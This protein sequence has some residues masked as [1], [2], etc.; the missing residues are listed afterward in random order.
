MKSTAATRPTTVTSVC[1]VY[2]PGVQHAGRTVDDR[3]LTT[4]VA[5]TMLRL[6]GVDARRLHSVE[7]EGTQALPGFDRDRF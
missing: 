6:L 5:P 4:Q 7:I 3:V 2:A 1:I